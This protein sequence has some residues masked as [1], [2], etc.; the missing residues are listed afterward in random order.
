MQTSVHA[1]RNIKVGRRRSRS[2]MKPDPNASCDDTGD[3]HGSSN[4]IKRSRLI[5]LH[6]PCLGLVDLPVEMRGAILLCLDRA[7]DYAACVAA[8]FLF[9]GACTPRAWLCHRA[10]FYA[11]QPERVFASDEC[12]AVVR[13][14][15]TRWG[16][17]SAARP[18][19]HDHRCI[20]GGLW[21]PRCKCWEH[22]TVKDALDR[23]RRSTVAFLCD[24]V[25]DVHRHRAGMHLLP[26]GQKCDGERNRATD[27]DGDGGGDG[28]DVAST[29]T[30]D[31]TAAWRS[32]GTT[33]PRHRSIIKNLAYGAL[34]SGRPGDGFYL[35]GLLARPIECSFR[36]TRYVT[37]RAAKAI[38]E[39]SVDEARSIVR[40]S[41]AETRKALLNVVVDDAIA[42][43]YYNLALMAHE[44]GADDPFLALL[45]RIVRDVCMADHFGPVW[46]RAIAAGHEPNTLWA[47]IVDAVRFS[48]FAEC[49]A[50]LEAVLRNRPPGVDMSSFCARAVRYSSPSCINIMRALGVGDFHCPQVRD[51]IVDACDADRTGMV[52]YMIEE[53]S[54]M[55]PRLL[56]AR[57]CPQRSPRVAAF[58]ARYVADLD[59]DAE[60]STVSK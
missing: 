5:D 26:N 37:K 45:C 25:L 22:R 1:D 18:D 41:P 7:T 23:G 55:D 9:R 11:E 21:A 42:F 46:K 3:N 30:G 54:D 56:L 53:V 58:L 29:G 31:D 35:L 52:R 60:R 20:Q 39:A 40:A 24:V 15:W 27:D 13:E 48:I 8:S 14:V 16:T 4:N 49:P 38:L 47:S 43:G 28:T 17:P 51:A 6:A 59:V 2:Q 36:A 34:W 57:T 32:D 19:A 44:E 10:L 12:V 50:A 33:R